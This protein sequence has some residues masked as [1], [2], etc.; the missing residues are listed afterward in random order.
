MPKITQAQR[1][2]QHGEIDQAANRPEGLAAENPGQI[3]ND[4]QQ[5]V[6]C[7]HRRALTIHLERP[8]NDARAAGKSML[9]GGAR[10]A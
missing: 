4:V 9:C 5:P 3:A 8:L 2:C 1:S 7:G 6:A 10:D